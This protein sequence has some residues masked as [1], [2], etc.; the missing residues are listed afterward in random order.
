MMSL[1]LSNQFDSDVFPKTGQPLFY[2][3]ANYTD[4]YQEFVQNL[5]S[6]QTD[7]EIAQR[8]ANAFTTLTADVDFIPR[9]EKEESKEVS[10]FKKNLDNF[11]V[12][13]QGF[14]MVK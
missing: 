13:I 10:K 7:Q 9:P 6:S 1:V 3:I 2:L 12:N 8:L 14:L 5:L 4:Q 11:I